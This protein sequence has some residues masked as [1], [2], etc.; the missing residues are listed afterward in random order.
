[1]MMAIIPP[2]VRAKVLLV[3]PPAPASLEILP[4][5]LAVPAPSPQSVVQ[6]DSVASGKADDVVDAIAYMV[7]NIELQI[8]N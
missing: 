5:E 7:C 8:R 2:V 3:D 4:A 1:M 6:G